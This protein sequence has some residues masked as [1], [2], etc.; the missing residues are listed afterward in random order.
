M[1]GHIGAALNWRFQAEAFAKNREII[2]LDQ[3]YSLASN[4]DTARDIASRLPERFDLV[5]WSIGG[6][7]N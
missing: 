2:V 3:L 6:Y 1:P 5:G 7:I 4:R